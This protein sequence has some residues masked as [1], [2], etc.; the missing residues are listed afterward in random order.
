MM[1][2]NVREFL[3][4][5]PRHDDRVLGLD[6]GR[7]TLE[8]LQKSDLADVDTGAT[9]CNFLVIHVNRDLTGEN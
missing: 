5:Y 8:W 4:G 2:R 9:R 7:A 3:R 6:G 1:F